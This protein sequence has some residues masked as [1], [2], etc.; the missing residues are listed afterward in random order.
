[1]LGILMERVHELTQGDVVIC[2]CSDHGSIDNQ[3]NISPNVK[4]AEA[5]LITID[6]SGKILDWKAWS[7][8][9]GGM[10]EI[11]LKDP[12]DEKSREILKGIVKALAEDPDSGILEVEDHEGA[13]K[14]GGFALADHVLIS[15]KGYEIRDNTTGPYCTTKL[16]QKAQHGYSENFEEMRASFMLQGKGIPA[17]EDL[18][19][20]QLID[21]APTLSAF[22]G[23]ELPQAEGVSRFR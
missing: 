2:V 7:Q 18:G 17:G 15:E 11:R 13:L 12:K 5:G 6:E 21:V 23:F 9:A 16:H 3:Y 19:A 10:A 8:R 20:V 4:L 14:R 22:M 1:M